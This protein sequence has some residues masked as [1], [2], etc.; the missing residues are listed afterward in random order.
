MGKY[1]KEAQSNEKKIIGKKKDER[2]KG[3]Q[4]KANKARGVNFRSVSEGKNKFLDLERGGKRENMIFGPICV[5]IPGS[6]KKTN[7]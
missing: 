4:I 1:E 2:E 3:A 7:Q 5:Y 6:R